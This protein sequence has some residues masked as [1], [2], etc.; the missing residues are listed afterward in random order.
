MHLVQAFGFC[1]LFL[2]LTCCNSILAAEPEQDEAAAL[3][4]IEG[5][6]TAQCRPRMG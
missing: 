4:A 1:L 5:K 2:T 3:K 6:W